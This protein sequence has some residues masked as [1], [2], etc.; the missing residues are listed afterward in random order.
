ME[1]KREIVICLGSS[2]YARGNQELLAIIEKFL[3]DKKINDKVSFHGNRCF[4]E[5]GNG[6]SLK[7]GAKLYHHVSIENVFGILEHSLSDLI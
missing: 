2:C 5:C 3:I 6:P 4:G 7:I 1:Y